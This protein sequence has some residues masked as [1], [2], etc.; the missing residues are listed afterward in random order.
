M[1]RDGY[2][3]MQVCLNG[4]KITDSYSKPKFRQSACDECGADTIHKCPNC[5][6]NIKGRYRGG[7]AGG[8]GPDVPDHCHECGEPYPWIDEDDGFTEIDSSALDEEL[9]NRAVPQHENG[10]YQSA[11]RTAFIILEERIREKG[12]F[13]RDIHGDDL[14]TRA[15]N[16]DNGE[17]TFGETG[18]EKQGMMFLYRGAMLSLRNPASHRFIEEADKDYARDV[19]HTVNLLLRLLKM[20]TDDISNTELRQVPETESVT[21]EKES[22]N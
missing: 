17:L 6:V 3:V 18:G 10:H 22:E 5:E 14:M 7:F 2:D 12:Q 4:H 9:T 8:P 21:D 15:F 11:V 20:N 16:P 13:S 1:R 19:I